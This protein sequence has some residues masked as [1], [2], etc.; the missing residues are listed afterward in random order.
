M[1]RVVIIGCG[2]GG[3]NLAN[4]LAGNKDFHV[5]VVDRNNYHFFPPLLYQ[6]ATGYLETSNICYPYRRLWRD[7]GNISFYMAEFLKV[8][9]PEKKVILSTGEL[10]YDYLVFATGTKTNYFGLENVQKNALPMKSLND[11]LNLRNYFLQMLET[12]SKTSDEHERKKLLTIV[13]AGA[14]PTG[15][16]ISGM[17]AEMKKKVFAKDYPELANKGYESHIYLVDAANTVLATMSKKSQT[18][19]FKALSALGVEIKTGMQI[20]DYANDTVTFANGETIETKTLVWAAGVVSY[21]FEGIPTESY[22]RGKRLIVDE[23][24]E[25]KG[26]SNV[27]A[28]GD[29]C[30]QTH[31]TRFPNGH[32]QM[33]QPAIQQG[34]LLAKNL[35]AIESARPKKPFSY[36]DKGSMAIIG[37][38]K[39]VVDMPKPRL[40]FKGFIAWF[41]WLFI[42]LLFLINYRNRIRTLYNWITAYFTKDQALRMIIRPEKTI[43]VSDKEN[44]SYL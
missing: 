12:A 17:L 4:G 35:R 22:G 3:I 42:H 26:L 32:P 33:A 28:V 24:N 41:V 14:G 30:L 1:K 5:T 7:K 11:A 37:W 40:H 15:I 18:D 8:E 39:A 19:T 29:T 16:E 44:S 34:H 13:V 20:K 6:V 2:F 10:Y 43:S 23:Y 38:N 21:G 27:F 31:D 36:F 25:V 9:L